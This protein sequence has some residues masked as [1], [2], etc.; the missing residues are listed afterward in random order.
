M[1]YTET[2]ALFD[3]HRKRPSK[4]IEL[5]PDFHFS[6]VLNTGNFYA[7]ALLYYHTK[8]TDP[9]TWTDSAIVMI[10]AGGIRSPVSQGKNMYIYFSIDLRSNMRIIKFV[11]VP[12]RCGAFDILK[13]QSLKSYG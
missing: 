10:N 6:Y 2:L 4:I 5:F 11:Y 3:Q 1:F 8:R 7:D 13:N 12:L 9:S